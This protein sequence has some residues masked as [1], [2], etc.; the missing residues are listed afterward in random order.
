MK[1]PPRIVRLR[2]EEPFGLVYASMMYGD[3]GMNECFVKSKTRS[4]K[5]MPRPSKRN[6]LAA[7]DRVAEINK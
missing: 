5:K 3:L 1:S 4:H 6:L 2:I 7:F